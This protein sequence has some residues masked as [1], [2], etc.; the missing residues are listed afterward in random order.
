M[1][2]TRSCYADLQSIAAIFA[3]DPTHEITL[4]KFRAV[5]ASVLVVLGR[6][7]CQMVYVLMR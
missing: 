3:K 7:V 5:N 1:T 4:L 6:L 2:R